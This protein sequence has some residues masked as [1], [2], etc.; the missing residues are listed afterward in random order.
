MIKVTKLNDHELVINSDL[1]ETIEAKPDTILSL[2]DGKK[3]IIK[4]SVDEVV[5]RVIKFRRLTSEGFQRPEVMA[6][7]SDEQQLSGV[8]RW[9]LQ[10][11]SVY[12]PG[13]LLFSWP[14]FWAAGWRRS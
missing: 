9:I 8:K 13:P 14:S 4:E 1:I 6:A 10:L 12:S 2:R 7:L 5:S 3:I 11:L